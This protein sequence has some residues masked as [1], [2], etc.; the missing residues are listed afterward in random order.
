MTSNDE[1]TGHICAVEGYRNHSLLAKPGFRPKAAPT[2]AGDL[3]NRTSLL[4]SLTS[5]SSAQASA[6]VPIY[7]RSV[8]SGHHSLCVRAGRRRKIYTN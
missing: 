4:T 6:S 7:L 5:P 3:I 8:D 1:I 2:A